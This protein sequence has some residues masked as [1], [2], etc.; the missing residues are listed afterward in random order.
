MTFSDTA[1]RK[2]IENVPNVEHIINLTNVCCEILQ[3]VREEFGKP[4]KINSGYRS[5]EL[6][7]AIG[8]SKTSQHAAGEAVDF[9]IYGVSN[10]DLAKWI[11]NTLIFDQLIL[12]FFDPEGDPN[13]GWVHCSYTKDR[14]NRQNALIINK[15]TG[16]KYLQWAP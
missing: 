13:S 8:S 5:I 6:C 11:Y 3:P 14:D 2:N 9:E 15:S 10:Y 1:I 12:E 7:E 16:G 4:V